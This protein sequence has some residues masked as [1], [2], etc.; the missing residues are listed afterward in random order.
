V[1]LAAPDAEYP[2]GGRDRDRR[3]EERE[4]EWSG[5]C[6]QRAAK[7]IAGIGRSRWTCWGEVMGF[8]VVAGRR[9]F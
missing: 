2:I 8:A 5:S 7:I 1:V 3:Y 4:M 9:R 6:S